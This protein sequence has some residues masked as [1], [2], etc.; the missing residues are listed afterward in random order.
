MCATTVGDADRP[1]AD[2]DERKVGIPVSVRY[3]MGHNHAIAPSAV[4]PAN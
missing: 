1:A 3:D 2:A 4:C